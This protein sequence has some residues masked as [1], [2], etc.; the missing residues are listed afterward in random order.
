MKTYH[1]VYENINFVNC[2]IQRMIVSRIAGFKIY[3]IFDG[4]KSKGER[5][6]KRELQRMRERR[7]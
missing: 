1:D 2:E 6:K 7:K 3:V 4:E 5:G